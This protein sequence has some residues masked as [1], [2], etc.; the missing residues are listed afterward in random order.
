MCRSNYSTILEVHLGFGD[1]DPAVHNMTGRL[2]DAT[3]EVHKN[4]SNTFLPS[5]VNFHYQSNLCKLSNITQVGRSAPVHAAALSAWLM[6]RSGHRQPVIHV[7][8]QATP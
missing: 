4:V 8:A 3:M 7:E 2:V 6:Y 1:F 5:A